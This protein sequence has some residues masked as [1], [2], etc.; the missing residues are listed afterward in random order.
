MKYLDEFTPG[1]RPNGHFDT[2]VFGL[3][4]FGGDFGSDF[5]KEIKDR[6]AAISEGDTAE[7]VKNYYACKEII[8]EFRNFKKRI[9]DERDDKKTG[10]TS[11]D[12]Y[13][14]LDSIFLII[15]PQDPQ[16]FLKKFVVL[17]DI[18]L[19]ATAYRDWKRPYQAGKDDPFTD[20]TYFRN[21]RK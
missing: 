3:E 14:D 8:N 13:F 2:S 5:V 21:G 15:P 10:E 6:T 17:L 12:G 9:E 20:K 11:E 18:S 16:E 4:R 19:S 7:E 1:R